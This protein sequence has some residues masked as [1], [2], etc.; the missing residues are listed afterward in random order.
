MCT[1]TPIQH[2]NHTNKTFFYTIFSVKIQWIKCICAENRIES[3][4][5]LNQKYDMIISVINLKGG[6]G[7]T[8]IAINLAVAF[9]NRGKKVCII[10]TDKEQ[11]SS[12][13]CGWKLMCY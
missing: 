4:P 3:L 1:F 10:D 7:K 11:L 2:I 13:A 9:A 12:V 8:T 5:I 6:V